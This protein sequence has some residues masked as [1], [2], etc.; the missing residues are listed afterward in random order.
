MLIQLTRHAPNA[1]D[2][3]YLLSK[4]PGAVFE[5]GFSAGRVVVFYPD[6]ADDRVTV[7][8]VTEIDPVGLV[9]FVGGEPLR[10]VH[11]AVFGVLALESEPVDPRL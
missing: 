4:H 2:I 1:P 5:R 11:Q 7:V 8:M 3:D 6:V 10:R 9:R